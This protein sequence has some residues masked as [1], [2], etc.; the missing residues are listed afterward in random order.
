LLSIAH[1]HDSQTSELHDVVANLS[2]ASLV[3]IVVAAA[4]LL[5]LLLLL[6][7]SVELHF[8]PLL[9]KVSTDSTLQEEWETTLLPGYGLSPVFGDGGISACGFH[10]CKA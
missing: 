7:S 10:S 9:Q 3:G 5:L 2:I 4:M 6:S 1:D 8:P